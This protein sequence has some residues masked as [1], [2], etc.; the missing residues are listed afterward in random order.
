M[1]SGCRVEQLLKKVYPYFLRKSTALGNQCLNSANIFCGSPWLYYPCSFWP[2]I[3]TGRARQRQFS[4]GPSCQSWRQTG[5]LRFVPQRWPDGKKRIEGHPWQL[6]V[7]HFKYGYDQKGSLAET[8]NVYGRDYLKHGRD[9]AAVTAIDTLDS[10]G[11][12]FKNG[13][14]IEADR[15]PGNASDDPKTLPLCESTRGRSSK[16][17]A[18]AKN[19]C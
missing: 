8:L 13:V 6:P 3:I 4:Q 11:D 15:F 17:L 19:F 16:H 2:L 12:G 14:E 10:D 5:S 1:N 7:C 9:V 18:S